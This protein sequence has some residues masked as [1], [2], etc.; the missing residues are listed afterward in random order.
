M[1]QSLLLKYQ[2]NHFIAINDIDR[3]LYYYFDW[4]ERYHKINMEFQHSHPFHEMM[5]VLSP[6]VSHIIEGLPYALEVGDIVLL[7]PTVL[8]KSVYPAGAPSQRL[9]IDFWFPKN[10]FNMPEHYLPLLNIFK[11]DKLVLRFTPEIRQNLF[12]V[13]DQIYTI[14]LS[15]N[16]LTH[17]ED[18]LM[19]HSL[20][21]QFLYGL[22]KYAD[23]NIYD[24]DVSIHSSNRK[25]YEITSYIHSHFAENLSLNVLSDTFY[26][27]PSHLSHQ[28]KKV[29]G[30]TLIN[31]I[32]R[33][34]ISNAKDMLLSADLPIATIAHACGFQS[35]SQFNRIFR[36]IY[37]CAPSAMRSSGLVQ[38]QCF[39][40]LEDEKDAT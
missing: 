10:M 38:A 37:G 32:Q 33:T 12:S 14:S 20:F 8:H 36:Q 5:I 27:S 17:P 21:I 13:I 6:G 23:Q 26:L 11:E 19:I 4:G 2:K 16:Y 35:L 29:N 22:M 31:Y 3:A 40:V 9:I 15:R 30:F 28:F 34:R 39:K 18:Q 25:I 7:P 24:G 1:K